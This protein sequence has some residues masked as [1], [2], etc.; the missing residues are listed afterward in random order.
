MEHTVLI[1]KLQPT[2]KAARNKQ[3]DIQRPFFFII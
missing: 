2:S 3:K 1:I